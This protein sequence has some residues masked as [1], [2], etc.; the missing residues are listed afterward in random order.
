MEHVK[1]FLDTISITSV[2]G[3]IVGWWTL[4]HIAALFSIIWTGLR[5]YESA[6]V[7]KLINKYFK[8]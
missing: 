5:I 8:K 1:H 2:I 4:P 3:S 7:Q 6:T